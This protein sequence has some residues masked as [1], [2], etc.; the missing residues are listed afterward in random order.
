MAWDGDLRVE[1]L[2]IFAAHDG[3][4]PDRLWNWL[5]AIEGS[6]RALWR[7]QGRR[8]RR[9]CRSPEAMARQATRRSSPD[10]LERE[11]IRS[12]IRHKAAKAARITAD[13]SKPDGSCPGCGA[14]LIGVASRTGRRPKWCS[15]RCRLAVRR[16]SI[17]ADS[18][19]LE[20]ERDLARARKARWK[21]R[22]K[23]KPELD[24]HQEG[25]Y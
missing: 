17:A 10:G 16:T 4:R 14:V 9:P 24:G 18:A 2:E 11:R 19:A 1:V 22:Q 21:E 23:G 6:R 7:L 25:L 5:A 12:R 8:R 3:G 20:A 13:L 15:G